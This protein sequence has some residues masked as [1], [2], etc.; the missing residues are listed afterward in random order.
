MALTYP[1][2]LK[3]PSMHRVLTAKCRA[4]EAIAEPWWPVRVSDHEIEMAVTE[5]DIVIG[6]CENGNAD[7]AEDTYPLVVIIDDD[8]VYEVQLDTGEAVDMFDY[9]MI[10][11]AANGSVALLAAPAE[12]GTNYAC[13]IVID[14]SPATAGLAHIVPVFWSNDASL[15]TE[16]Q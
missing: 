1:W 8:V 3:R 5:G 10:S 4:A 16:Y 7:V 2:R 12:A 9:V 14:Y 6:V 11:D 13:G 15:T